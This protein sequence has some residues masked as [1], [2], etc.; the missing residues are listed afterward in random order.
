MCQVKHFEKGIP[1]RDNGYY[2]PLMNWTYTIYR[3]SKSLRICTAIEDIHTVSQELTNPTYI[4]DTLSY[5]Q[6][7]VP[8]MSHVFKGYDILESQTSKTGDAVF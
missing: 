6:V 7:R 5:G 3:R 1:A 2:T 4:A 8:H